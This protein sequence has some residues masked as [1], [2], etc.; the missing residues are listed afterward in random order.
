VQLR[1]LIRKGDE[2]TKREKQPVHIGFCIICQEEITREVWGTAK[3]GSWKSDPYF[4][5]KETMICEECRKAILKTIGR[6]GV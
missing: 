1:R 6:E 2:M 3:E 5:P 4:A